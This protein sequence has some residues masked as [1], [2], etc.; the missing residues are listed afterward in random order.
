MHGPA[1]PCAAKREHSFLTIFYYG[2]ELDRGGTASRAC[3]FH[4]VHR[5]NLLA[6]VQKSGNVGSLSGAQLRV[7]GTIVNSMP[8]RGEP[9]NIQEL[10]I[11]QCAFGSTPLGAKYLNL[12]SETF[13]PSFAN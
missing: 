6:E 13:C 11:V 7:L 4:F 1:G 12:A 8:R 9:R 10:E 3:G 5:L 2:I